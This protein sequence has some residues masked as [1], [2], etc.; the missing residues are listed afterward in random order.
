VRKLEADVKKEARIAKTTKPLG[1]TKDFARALK[2]SKLNGV[3]PFKVKEV[4]RRVIGESDE[5]T[6][7]VDADEN[8]PDLSSSMQH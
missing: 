7:D 6:F 2:A 5:S 1:P 4:P 8:K 3:T